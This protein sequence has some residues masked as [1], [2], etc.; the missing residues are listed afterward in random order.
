MVR[1]VKGAYWDSEI[2][3][4]QE[5]GLDDYPVFTRKAATDVSYLACAKRLL[6]GRRRVLPAIRHPQRAHPRRGARTRRRRARDWEFQRLHGMGEA[7]YD[8]GRRRRQDGPAVPRL[9]AGRQPRGSA[10]LSGAAAAGE[11]RQHLVRQPHRRRARSRST[12]IVADPV[13]RLARLPAKP[14]PRIPLPRDLYRPERQN[15]RGPRPRRS[16]RARRAARRARRGDAPA[17]ARRRRS[18]AAS[19][20]PAR[21]R[22]G[23]STRATGG[24]QIGT[25]VDADAA[26]RRAGARRAPRAPRRHGTRRRPMTRAAM[27]ERAADLY[28]ARPRRADG[29][30]RARGRPDPPGGAVGGARGGRFPALLRRPRPRRF[31]RAASAARPDRRAQRASRCTAAASSPASRRG[32]SR[33][34]SSPARSRR[35]SPPAMRSSPSRPSRRR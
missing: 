15:S 13:A 6:A 30:D 4:A 18:S 10:R 29:A 9:C 31:R 12:T 8:R 7:L 23:R 27:L 19:S 21:R 5:R 35:R 3:R 33:W 25:V 20:A 14:H 28:E 22:A 34:R 17:V 32:I 24:A 2:K 16:A 11:R 1:L 26:T